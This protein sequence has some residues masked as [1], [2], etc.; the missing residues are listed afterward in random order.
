ML[1]RVKEMPHALCRRTLVRR[2]TTVAFDYVTTFKKQDLDRWSRSRS[3]T[4]NALPSGKVRRVEVRPAAASVKRFA[5]SLD[6]VG[7]ARSRQVGGRD[8]YSSFAGSERNGATLL[9]PSSFRM[10]GS[11]WQHHAGSPLSRERQPTVHSSKLYVS[12]TSPAR[13]STP[14]SNS[15]TGQSIGPPRYVSPLIRTAA[16]HRPDAT[17][18]HVNFAATTICAIITRLG[19]GRRLTFATGS[20]SWR[21]LS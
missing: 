19:D 12:T 9:S 8:P 1:G 20:W 4:T 21:K 10:V 14:S 16:Q 5:A 7:A 17:N 15:Q 13:R 2:S 11:K 18:A 3:A 6:G